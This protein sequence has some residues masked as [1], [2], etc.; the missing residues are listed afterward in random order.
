MGEWRQ[1]SG[2]WKRKSREVPQE[3]VFS[4]AV[5]QQTGSLAWLGGKGRDSCGLG[6]T[7]ASGG[8]VGEGKDQRTETGKEGE[9]WEIWG[10][11]CVGR[12]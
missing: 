4:G 6:C 7:G 1:T 5:G 11:V 8:S 3:A 12:G 2:R 9:R 10:M